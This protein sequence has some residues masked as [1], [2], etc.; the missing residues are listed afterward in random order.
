[1]RLITTLGGRRLTHVVLCEGMGAR[2]QRRYRSVER[3]LVCSNAGLLGY[4]SEA[5]RERGPVLG[6]IAPDEVDDFYQQIDVF[7]FPSLYAQEAE[8]LV[9][10]DAGR[11]GVPTIAFAVGCL[12]GIVSPHHIV[13]THADFAQAAM[14]ILAGPDPVCPSPEI[15]AA[16][17]TR[18]DAALTAHED[19]VRHLLR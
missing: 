19:L 17:A 12:P 15:A 2:L 8:P 3:V 4:A 9:V 7:V 1:M 11:H 5:V 18:R 13:P 16:F 10:L 14:A 6:P